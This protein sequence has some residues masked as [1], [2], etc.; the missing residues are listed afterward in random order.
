MIRAAVL[1]PHAEAH[2]LQVY[3]KADGAPALVLVLH[4]DWNGDVFFRTDAAG[5]K[6]LIGLL[7]QALQAMESEEQ[8]QEDP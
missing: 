1:P 5:A 6:H 3:S 7:E 2:Y 4:N 8:Q